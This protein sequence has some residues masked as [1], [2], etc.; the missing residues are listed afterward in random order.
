MQ[1]WPRTSR[2]GRSSSTGLTS[3]IPAPAPGPCSSSSTAWLVV[4]QRGAPSCPTRSRSDRRSTSRGSS[5]CTAVFSSSTRLSEYAGRLREQQSWIGGR[6]AQPVC[7]DLSFR[8]AHDRQSKRCCMTC[9]AFCNEDGRA[10]CRTSCD[11]PRAVRDDSS[12]HRRETAG[13]GRTLIHVVARRRG[14]AKHVLPPISRDSRDVGGGLRDRPH[15]SAVSRAVGSSTAATD[16]LNRW[17]ASLSQSRDRE[18]PC[19]A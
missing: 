10:G 16:G 9:C 2:S 8:L 12:L 5:R 1:E 18:Q 14:L 3:A 17:V 13:L 15:R 11:R 19:S 7:R 6:S 4:R